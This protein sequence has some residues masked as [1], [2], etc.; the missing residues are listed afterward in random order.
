M[1]SN[2]AWLVGAL[3]GRKIGTHPI[4]GDKL[5]PGR[6]KIESPPMGV[7]LPFSSQIEEPEGSS[8]TILPIA[9]FI[10]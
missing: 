8:M 1:P 6:G 10:P 5:G 2:P 7:Q 3:L 4:F 9:Q